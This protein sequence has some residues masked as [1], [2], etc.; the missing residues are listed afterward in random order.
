M[1]SSTSFPSLAAALAARVAHGP[2]LP[3]VRDGELTLR[4]GDLGV[5]AGRVSAALSAA[6][7]G[8][9]DAVGMLG[10]RSWEATVTAV[11]ILGAG[12][13]CVPVD[14]QYPSARSA[15]MLAGA[16]ARIAVAL[17]GHEPLRP[18]PHHSVAWCRFADLTGE[19]AS[20]AAHARPAP[21]SPGAGRTGDDVAY[22][23]YTS[24]TTGRPK[25]VLFP[26]ARWPGSPRA[27]RLGRPG[28]A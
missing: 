13:V 25:P 3:A 17:S 1:D 15:E 26:T 9:G 22:V 23:L 12:A 10:V 16:G 28:R 4:Y 20:A 6:G 24:G 5:L 8:P 27:R 11:G 21:A 7:V 18:M 2:E 14:A 19:S